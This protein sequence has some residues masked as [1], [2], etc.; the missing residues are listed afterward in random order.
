VALLEL[1]LAAAAAAGAAA[2][3]E[4]E[5]ARAQAAASAGA[6]EE[7]QAAMD[8]YEADPKNFGRRAAKACA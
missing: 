8:E 2:G 5:E 7:V 6:L 4:R 1:E 3:R